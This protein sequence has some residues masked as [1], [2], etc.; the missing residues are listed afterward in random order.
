MSDIYELRINHKKDI[1]DNK[2]E[3]YNYIC[4][5]DKFMVGKFLLVLYNRASEDPLDTIGCI[6]AIGTKDYRKEPGCGPNY[7]EIIN[8]SST[9][10]EKEDNTQN[11]LYNTNI[12]INDTTYTVANQDEDT[13]VSD[14][15]DWNNI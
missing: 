2:D 4:N 1:F 10:Y 8:T 12:T 9:I 11:N 13:T 14:A 6:L 7:F 15:L 5:Y 3:A